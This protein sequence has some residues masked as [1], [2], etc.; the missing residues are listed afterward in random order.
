MSDHPIGDAVGRVLD[1]LVDVYL[2]DDA[3]PPIMKGGDRWAWALYGSASAVAGRWFLS[4]PAGLFT[5]RPKEGETNTG[6]PNPTS[7]EIPNN[8]VDT[9]LGA[10]EHLLRP[11]LVYSMMFMLLV[12][13]AIAKSFKYG[14]QL[15]FLLIGFGITSAMVAIMSL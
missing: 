10:L 14:S 1:R 7:A 12:S 8:F 13:I 2:A 9:F 5:P 3:R 6:D 4:L 11:D 15:R